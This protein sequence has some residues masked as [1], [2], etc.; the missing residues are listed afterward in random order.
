[1]GV[2]KIREACLCLRKMLIVWNSSK[3]IKQRERETAP[4][5]CARSHALSCN[6]KRQFRVKMTGKGT[7]GELRVAYHYIPTRCLRLYLC[8]TIVRVR[9]TFPPSWATGTCCLT[10]SYL[11]YDTS[12]ILHFNLPNTVSFI[13]HFALNTKSVVRSRHL[14]SQH[15]DRGSSFSISR[16]SVQRTCNPRSVVSNAVQRSSKE[17]HASRQTV[18]S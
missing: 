6:S 7:P 3:P 12:P 13:L 18:P 4:K 1:M 10:C 8:A 9:L 16:P 17:L 15:A 2:S 11:P 5:Y 14:A